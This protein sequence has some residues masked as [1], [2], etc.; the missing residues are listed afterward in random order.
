M[1]LEE[2]HRRYSFIREVRGQGLMIGVELTIPGKQLVLD[3]MEEGLL[4]NCTHETV[5]RF[6]PPYIITDKEIDRGVRILNR[7]FKK[8]AKQAKTT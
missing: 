8:A 1:K 7:V 5:L 6:L 2:L 3:G 4:M